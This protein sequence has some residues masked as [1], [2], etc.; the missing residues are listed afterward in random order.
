MA[1]TSNEFIIDQD[2]K[3]TDLI[4][5]RKN[6][7]CKRFTFS[8]LSNSAHWASASDGAS[9]HGTPIR[10]SS[11][12]QFSTWFALTLKVV[13]SQKVFSIWSHQLLNYNYFFTA[14]RMWNADFITDPL[15]HCLSKFDWSVFLNLKPIS[16]FFA[17]YVAWSFIIK[18]WSDVSRDLRKSHFNFG[19]KFEF[20]S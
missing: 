19:G 6:M 2:K 18:A 11:F 5:K 14:K 4:K 13:K 16:I 15:H 1:K 12:L 3:T 10:S 9:T 7:Q 8:F 20:R 17:I